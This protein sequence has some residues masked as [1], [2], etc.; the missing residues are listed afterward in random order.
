MSD[1]QASIIEPSPPSISEKDRRWAILQWLSVKLVDA[2]YDKI[3]E[4]AR[5]FEDYIVGNVAGRDIS[6]DSISSIT[7]LDT[8]AGQILAAVAKR[9]SDVASNPEQ[10]ATDG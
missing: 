9:E 2:P 10:A 5:D 4:T 8:K 6:D 3:L 1:A 7:K